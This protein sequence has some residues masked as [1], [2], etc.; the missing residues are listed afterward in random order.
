M[1]RCNSKSDFSRL[2]H[3]VIG[4]ESLDD[5][6]GF[7]DCLGLWESSDRDV[8][9]PGTVLV[10]SKWLNGRQI[11][12][13]PFMAILAHELGHACGTMDEIRSRNM[14]DNS[15]AEETVA[16]MYVYKWGF[17]GL[18][19]GKKNAGMSGGLKPGRQEVINGTTYVLSSDFTW[20]AFV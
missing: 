12:E 6:D 17:A 8:N 1:V 14:P 10:R 3:Q 5:T 9:G 18:I 16:D 20:S 11:S 13:K 4:I 19:K 7:D 15:W 2:L